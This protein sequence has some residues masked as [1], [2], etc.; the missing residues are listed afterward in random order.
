MRNQHIAR[1]CRSTPKIMRY[2]FNLYNN[3]INIVIVLSVFDFEPFEPTKGRYHTEGKHTNSSK[4]SIHHA[5][6]ALRPTRVLP[7]YCCHAIPRARCDLLTIFL[8]DAIFQTN[9]LTSSDC[10][11]TERPAKD[12]PFVSEKGWIFQ[13]PAETGVTGALIGGHHWDRG[14]KGG[15]FLGL[16]QGGKL[17]IQCRSRWQQNLWQTKNSIILEQGR[18]M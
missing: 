18:E 5:T 14:G 1:F 15:I 7:C 11:H 16:V 10:I 17:K 3:S 6:L 12:W 13:N 2:F 9:D 4:A 8:F